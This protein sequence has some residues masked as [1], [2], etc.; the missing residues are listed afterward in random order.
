MDVMRPGYNIDVPDVEFNADALRDAILPSVQLLLDNPPLRSR[1][2]FG[3]R[4]DDVN[5]RLFRLEIQNWNFIRHSIDS[6]L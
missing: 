1:V 4:I 3:R 5:D 2:R 6:K